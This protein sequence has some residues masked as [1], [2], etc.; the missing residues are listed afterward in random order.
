MLSYRHWKKLSWIL[1]GECCCRI[2][3]DS[4]HNT[5]LLPTH[6]RVYSDAGD[7]NR[8]LLCLICQ[9]V[10]SLNLITGVPGNA[11]LSS[12][13]A[14]CFSKC[15]TSIKQLEFKAVESTSLSLVPGMN[16]SRSEIRILTPT[17]VLSEVMIS[18]PFPITA[19]ILPSGTLM[20][21]SCSPVL[22]IW[23]G[24][25]WWAIWSMGGWKWG[26]GGNWP[27][28]IIWVAAGPP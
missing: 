10:C 4:K 22:S 18:P 27:Q 24:L 9:K 12:C 19:P 25:L 28:C 6:P 8:H 13:W 2:S 16:M 26:P 15:P 23:Y 20:R 11:D 21:T 5:V 7:T 1:L 3:I 14:M 17:S